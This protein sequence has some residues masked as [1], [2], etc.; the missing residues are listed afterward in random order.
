MFYL[1]KLSANSKFCKH[2]FC[3]GANAFL[4]SICVFCRFVL[5]QQWLRRLTFIIGKLYERERERLINRHFLSL[6]GSGNCNKLLIMIN[7]CDYLRF[8]TV[9]VSVSLSLIRL[10]SWVRTASTSPCHFTKRI[11]SRD[12]YIIHSFG[13]HNKGAAGRFDVVV[14]AVPVCKIYICPTK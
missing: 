11:I 12:K 10:C 2:L 6:R 13:A 9:S 7:C 5:I 8:N 1:N 4:R 3:C 14:I